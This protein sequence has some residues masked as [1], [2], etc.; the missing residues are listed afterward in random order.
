MTELKGKQK[1]F[2]DEYIKSGNATEAYVN[3]GY[4]VKNN[5]TARANASRMLTNAN[6]KAYIES[7]MKRLESAK[8]ASAKEV[9]EYLTSVMRG[10]QTETVAT[11]K[12]IFKGIEVSAKDRIT[13]AKEL[14]KR[15]PSD[16]ISNAQLRKMVAEAKMAE[17]KVEQ[18]NSDDLD[19][20]VNINFNIPKEDNNASE[21]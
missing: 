13:A 17:Y 16:P 5:E 7:R 20:T 1:K 9:L 2:A 3:A 10:E 15:Y 8:L 12:G 6:V 18:L 19:T 4:K 14:L 11:A 21:S